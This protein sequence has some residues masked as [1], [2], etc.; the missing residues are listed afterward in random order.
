MQPEFAKGLSNQVFGQ[1][2]FFP[3]RLILW[4]TG[5]KVKAD[6]EFAIVA[7]FEGS[8]LTQFFTG[9]HES[10]QGH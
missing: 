3:M 7:A 5:M 4:D 10:L 1:N 2:P 9:N 8:K 6:G